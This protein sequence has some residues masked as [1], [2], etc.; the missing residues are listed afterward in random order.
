MFKSPLYLIGQVC[1]SSLYLQGQK[2]AHWTTNRCN[3]PYDITKLIAADGICWQMA[4]GYRSFQKS[5]G[6]WNK[7]IYICCSPE[8]K[9]TRLI[10]LVSN[11]VTLG[12]LSRWH[13]TSSIGVNLSPM[14]YIYPFFGL[15]KLGPSILV[16]SWEVKIWKGTGEAHC[17][18]QT[19]HFPNRSCILTVHLS[20]NLWF[21][22]IYLLSLMHA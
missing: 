4:N 14:I 15:Q 5:Q 8:K 2:T 1:I 7:Q 16:G 6:N 19:E 3:D 11:M 21:P 9:K 18:K 17:C 20:P 12:C 22:S 10:S 13:N